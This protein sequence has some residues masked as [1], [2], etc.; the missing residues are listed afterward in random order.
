MIRQ[1][2]SLIW[3]TPPA[4]YLS[5]WDRQAG[6]PPN[7]G[8]LR[9]LRWRW[10]GTMWGTR[11]ENGCCC[12]SPCLPPRGS[13]CRCCVCCYF[14]ARGGAV[15][16]AHLEYLAAVTKF[17]KHKCFIIDFKIHQKCTPLSTLP[18]CS[19]WLRDQKCP[20]CKAYREKRLCVAPQVTSLSRKAALLSNAQHMRWLCTPGVGPQQVVKACWMINAVIQLR[21]SIFKL[22]K[23]C[24]GKRE[25]RKET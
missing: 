11:T 13:A 1:G 20:L 9:Y 25:K 3:Q 2:S 17:Q 7:K 14:S 12:C 10:W 5:P 4:L 22:V 15:P 8:S 24:H 19:R 16:D 23:N 18:Y 6:H 21:L